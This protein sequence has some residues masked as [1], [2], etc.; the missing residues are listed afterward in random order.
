[1][2]IV[3]E[4]TKYHRFS[5]YYDYS[6]ERVDFCKALKESFGWNKFS[7]ESVGEVRRWVFSDSMFIP[8]LAE[9]FPDIAID[10]QVENIVRQE[11]GFAAKQQQKNE[12]IDTIRTKEDTDF[13]IKGLK[14]ELYPYQK[15]GVEFLVASNGRAIIA[16]AP[17]CISGDA[18]I[19][20]N[21]GGNAKQ[22]TMRDL[23]Y[24]FNG[25]FSR[26]NKSW[27]LDIPSMTRSLTPDGI[28]SLQKIGK[29]L[30]MGNKNTVIVTA[31][32]ITGKE[33]TIQL[34]SDHRISTPQGWV[35]AGKL[36]VGGA[37]TVN[38][39][40]VRYC[41]TCKANT[42]HADSEYS[43]KYLKNYG[44]CKTCIYRFIRK[45]TNSRKFLTG[46]IGTGEFLDKDGYVMVSGLYFHPS[47][48]NGREL[49]K[50][51]LV[52]EAH[53]NDVSYPEWT[54]MCKTNNVPEG[55]FFVDSSKFA[56]HHKDRYKKNNTIG[57]LKMIT[58]SAHALEH[59]DEHIRKLWNVIPSVAVITGVTA[60]GVIDVYDIQMAGEH[61]NFIVNG[62]VVH[63]CGKTAQ[64]LAYIKHMGFKRSLVVTPASVKFSWANEVTK[65]TNM[66]SV[67]IDSKTD[68]S[69]IDAS[70]QIWIINYDVLKKHYAQ[71]SKI[72]FDSMIGDECFVAGTT[73]D[74]PDGPVGI[75]KI[76]IGDVVNNVT[77][78]GVVR[79]VKKSISKNIVKISFK[80][81]LPIFCTLN[82]P[83]L[84]S[85]GW[86]RAFEL[87][88]THV[89]ITT[90][91]ALRILQTKRI[92]KK[93]SFLRKILLSEMENVSTIHQKE[94]IYKG[95][96]T[97][98]IDCI[99]CCS[100][101]KSNYCSKC[102]DS[103]EK[104]E[105]NVFFSYSEKN[106]NNTKKDRTQ[107]KN[108]WWKWSW[109][110][111]GRRK[112]SSILSQCKMEP[113]YKNRSMEWFW[114]SCLLQSGYSF[115]RIIACRGSR[116]GI[117]L[118]INKKKTRQKKGKEIRRVRVD[119]ITILKQKDIE[120][121]GGSTE[122]IEVYNL[123]VEGHPSF[124][125]NGLTVH[126]CQLIK[127]TGAIRTKAFRQISRDI[128]SI[129]LLSG[130]PLLSR[131]SEL[132]SLL[133]IIDPKTWNNWY[134]YAR[135]FCAMKQ[136]RWG[137]DTSGASNIEE[138]HSRIK[139][140]FIRR[141]K[142]MVLK[143][144]P[145]KTFINVPIEL[146]KETQKQYDT[147]ANNLA[148]YLRK[149][150]G[151]QP[152]EVA[153]TMA[154]EKLAQLNILR[155]LGASGKTATAIELAE[156]VIES[157]EKVLVF[158]S[159]MAPLQKL[160]DHFGDTAVIITGQT[161][162]D[163][164]GEIVKQFQTNPK[165]KVF[166]G[167][168]K[169]AGVGITLTAAQSFIGLD[170]PWNPADLQQAVDRL[171]RPGQIATSVNIYQI[172]AKDTID[173]DMKDIL[174]KKQGIFDQVIEGK[175]ADDVKHSAMDAAVT[176]VLKFH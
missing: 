104:K 153:K 23:F 77:G 1:M 25:G 91:E 97:E 125:V 151:K 157:G 143:E 52:Y 144:L 83:F 54:D 164:R 3:A 81:L 45:N 96:F 175:A 74:T 17:G 73:V 127:S 103:N 31:K 161:P 86:V 135:R 60:G 100:S 85:E 79:A 15:V 38:G 62:I 152:P 136:T 58:H 99:A 101:E 12:K 112:N 113:S 63:N 123:Q 84:T 137:M 5:L 20:V 106:V 51:V 159:F 8:V 114:I 14:K 98:N 61:K 76:K 149:F 2:K 126:N 21:R 89:I 140:Y 80:G 166:L 46:K 105:S 78:H 174:D 47:E 57:N 28:F 130:T 148:E 108:P 131:P 163:E 37:I 102:I 150:S 64:A 6:P 158:S 59:K 18:K 147:A 142:T 34:T 36:R 168:Y 11:H 43:K 115:S 133:N 22:I 156:S 65:W 70:I 68:L 128:P 122:G 141:D 4:K 32:T 107:T 118:F 92:K 167:G 88:E 7:F 9:R 42:P 132:F 169:S 90:Y 129:I 120:S 145:P 56:V 24:K 173:D 13:Q 82:H 171:H 117:S 53:R 39:D 29:V 44:K 49:R 33:Y 41:D 110:Y 26:S 50:H 170:F 66:T 138:L 27:N 19:I 72:R 10:A 154:A 67:V 87:N 71:L 162:V 165:V 109:S 35:E 48:R 93:E 55:A 172:I 69:K 176:R 119:S 116:W 124:S 155:Q 121:M 30:S 146:D 139:R 16:D 94:N 111:K 160:K 75:E 40:V 95:A 134:D